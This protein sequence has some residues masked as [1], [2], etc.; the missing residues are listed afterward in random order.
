MG[1]PAYFS[2]IIKNYPNIIQNKSV[3][4][5]IHNLYLDSNSIIY[6][7][8]RNIDETSGQL[9]EEKLIKNV[10][11]KLHY[12]ILT[13]K[14]TERVIIAFDGVAPVAKL[15]Q[16]RTRRVK[17]HILEETD[18]LCKKDLPNK[19]VWNKVAIT[20]G[21]QFMD[22]L[23]ITIQ[24]HFKKPS[25]FGTKEIIVSSSHDCGEGEHKIFEYIRNNEDTH[26][27]KHTVIYG[28]DADLIMLSILHLPVCHHIYLFR[29]T[30]EFIKQ[31]DNSLNANELYLLHIPIIADNIAAFMNSKMEMD[32]IMKNMRIYDYIFLCFFLGNDF[33]PHFPCLNIRTNGMDILIEC[34]ASLFAGTHETLIHNKKIVWKN[35]KKLISTLALSEKDYILHEYKLR[36]KAEKRFYKCE[37]DSEI[38]NKLTNLPTLYRKKE[39]YINPNEKGWESRYYD[40]LFNVEYNKSRMKQICFNYLEALEWTTAYYMDTCKNWRWKYNYNYAPLMSDLQQYIPYFDDNLVDFC[41]KN[42]VSP[43]CQLAYVLPKQ[44]L[45]LLPNK[46][47]EKLLEKCEYFYDVNNFNI[48]WSFCKYLWESH[49]IMPHINISN[50]EHILEN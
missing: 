39:H 23:M 32:S 47:R 30:P 24:N 38:D 43:Y 17:S 20:P 44:H 22:K 36:E 9:F 12:Y 2:Y 27:D 35:V 29:E 15:E 33:M 18:K 3:L 41:E 34:Y 14:P 1:I 28:L 13:L 40:T 26:V 50:L 49:L 10:C 25:S 42:P 7:A 6:D 4:K 11:E 48:E 21:T 45:T 5:T 31:L 16:Q 37:T 8:V 46:I 19:C